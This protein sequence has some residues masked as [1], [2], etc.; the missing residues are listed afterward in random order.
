MDTLYLELD[1]A[2]S[3][4]QVDELS[5]M[6]ETIMLRDLAKRGPRRMKRPDRE[7]VKDNEA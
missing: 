5:K 7:Q 4:H 3:L 6:R 2:F 1:R